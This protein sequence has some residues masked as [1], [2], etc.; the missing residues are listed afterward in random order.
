V[1]VVVGSAGLRPAE[2]DE[3]DPSPVGR[4]AD[5]A[6]AASTAGA[7]V[8]V[9]AK[10]GEDGAGD[11]YVLALGRAG[12]GHAAVL[13]DPTI[14]TPTGSGQQDGVVPEAADLE[15][16]LRYLTDFRV[17]VLAEPLDPAAARVLA[18]AVEFA[19]S[20]LVAALP[21][22][23]DTTGLPAA[24]TL[25]EAPA[26][27]SDGGF[28][29]FVGLYAAGLDRGMSPEQAFGEAVAK[30]GWERTAEDDL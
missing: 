27:D 15:L 29:A 10:V 12:V 21:P 18:E 6:H 30:T 17:V 13:R 4:A 9:V 19:G 26:D 24:A 1:I 11:A 20:H 14:R 7:T 16:A 25:F 23:A 5:I 28:G 8:E 3:R 22:A 2:G